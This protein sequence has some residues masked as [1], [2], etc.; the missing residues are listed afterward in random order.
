MVRL[1]ALLIR[2]AAEADIIEKPTC[3]RRNPARSSPH[4]GKKLLPPRLCACYIGPWQEGPAN[5]KPPNFKVWRT[6]VPAFQAS[7]LP[8]VRSSRRVRELRPAG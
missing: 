7:A 1:S 3:T 2:D 6:P 8:Q 4:V 5:S